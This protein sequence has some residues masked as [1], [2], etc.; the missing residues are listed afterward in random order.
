MTI[1]VHPKVVAGTLAGAVV[2]IIVWGLSYFLHVEQPPEVVGAE[3]VVVS[4]VI[5]YLVPGATT[6][7]SGGTVTPA[8]LPLPPPPPPPPAPAQ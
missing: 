2:T 4:T 7:A 3:V 8:P 6:D 5:A 1:T